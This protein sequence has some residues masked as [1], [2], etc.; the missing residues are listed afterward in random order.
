METQNLT[1]VIVVYG[2]PAV[3]S[4]YFHVVIPSVAGSISGS[5]DSK[6]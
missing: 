5:T 4:L 1:I 2:F 3:A 6:L